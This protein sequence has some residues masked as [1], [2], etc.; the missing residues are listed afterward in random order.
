[1]NS[2]TAAIADTTVERQ[3]SSLPRW[4]RLFYLLV[5]FAVFTILLSLHLSRQ[6]IHI[7][8]RSSAV[9]QAWTERLHECSQ[10]GHLAGGVNA[11]GNDVFQSHQVDAEEQK[12]Q[13]ALRQFNERL[14]AFQQELQANID[15]DGGGALPDDLST[16]RRFVQEM[17]EEAGRLFG[18]L[19]RE[20]TREAGTSMAAMDR[21]YARANQALERVRRE[22]AAIQARH[23]A[24]QT[25]AAGSLQRFQY[26]VSALILLMIAGSVAYGH[27]VRR[28]VESATR[29]KERLIE[30]LRDSETR[31]DGRVRERTD[32]L[33]QAN[34]ALRKEEEALRE[35]ERRYRSL[36]QVRQQLLKQL[37]SAQEDERR[38]IARDLHDEIGQ[39]LTS[40]LIG[41]RTVADAT[42]LETA[43]G[44]AEDLR[45]IGVSALEEVRRLARGLR[46]SVL[47]DLGLSAAL[48]RFAADYAQAHGIEVTVQAPDPMAGRLPEEIETALYRIAQEALTNTAKHASA[49]QVRIVVEQEPG[50]VQLIVSDD[51]RGFPCDEPTPIGRL[52]LSGMQERA[53]LLNGSVRVESSPGLGTRVFV[54]IPCGEANHGDHSGPSGGRPCGPAG[55]AADAHQRPAGHGSGGRGRGRSGSPEASTVAPAGGVDPR[56]DD[57]GRQ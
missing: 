32:E 29:E 31:L 44:R 35:S 2:A 3:R 39:A 27:R 17:A 46:P 30:A 55:R 12:M 51:G 45:R 22:I 10:L 21:C 5:A 54:R 13:A 1:M 25:A 16:F 28:Q 8:L 24:N 52:G 41:L 57:A 9:N 42:T 26:V 23:L 47:D 36:V 49:R 53:A 56:L 33:V 4:Y 50:S 14:E 34:E 40:M 19:R 11:P 20:Q 7:Y 15:G 38:R 48:E 6:Y 43:R 37:L 18:Y